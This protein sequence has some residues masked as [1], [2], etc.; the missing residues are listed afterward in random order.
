MLKEEVD[1][2]AGEDIIIAVTDYNHRN[3]EVRTIASA[4][5]S[6]G[7][8]TLTLSEPLEKDHLVVDVPELQMGD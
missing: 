8:T 2:V 4:N 3:S 1:W 7:K 5:T 6:G